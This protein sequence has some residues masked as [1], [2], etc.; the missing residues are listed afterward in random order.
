[1]PSS[2]AT[3]SATARLSPVSITTS[4]PSSCSRS[5]RLARFRPDGVGDGE[6][7]QHAP[8]LDEVDRR[9]ARLAEAVGGLGKSSGGS[10]PERLQER[11]AADLERRAL[12]LGL[13][14]AAGDGLEARA[15]ARRGRAPRR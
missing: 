6:D 15:A 11:R 5:H 12:D 1:M 10:A 2:R 3:L 9:L 4:M 8:V 7:G 14:A 13:D